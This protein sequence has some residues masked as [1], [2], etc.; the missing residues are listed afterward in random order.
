MADQA[1]AIADGVMQITAGLVK[2]HYNWGC[3][4]FIYYKVAGG[5]E[6]A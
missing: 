1:G 2:G 5:H 3:C 4:F 6:H